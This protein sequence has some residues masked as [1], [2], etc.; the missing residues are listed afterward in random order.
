MD[1]NEQAA[2]EAILYVS[3]DE[4][5][6]F[7][8]IAENL[9]QTIQQVHEAVTAYQQA[10]SQDEQRGL[11]VLISGEHVRLVT[12]TTLA[13][14][15][16]RYYTITS[17]NLSQAALEVLAIIAYQQP[18]TRIEID[19]IRGVQSSSSLQTLLMYHLIAEKGRK[20]VPG[21]PI[22]YGTTD[23]FLN[24]FGLQSLQELPALTAFE[25]PAS[26]ASA[27]DPAQLLAQFN[28][29]LEKNNGE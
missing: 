7:S 9:H 8:K 23:E 16:K 12:K 3:G 25:Q 22:L 6:T 27:V 5:I 15:I 28:Q 10:L 29:V 17:N 18:I 13:S 4:G 24:Y 21:R 2:L 1:F 20:D 14:L 11:Q 19:E 26:A